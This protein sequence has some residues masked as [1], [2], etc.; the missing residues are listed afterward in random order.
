[1]LMSKAMIR[2]TILLFGAT[3][4]SG[5]PMASLAEDNVMVAFNPE[6][7]YT[8]GPYWEDIHLDE[9]AFYFYPDAIS[10][11]GTAV[12]G[13]GEDDDEG[14]TYT[15]Y[16]DTITGIVKLFPS[17]ELAEESANAISADGSVVVGRM[18]GYAAR[19]VVGETIT[20]D[21][22]FGEDYSSEAKH[23]SLD[24][25][26]VAGEIRDGLNGNRRVVHWD[27]ENGLT[28]VD[29]GA[30]W[31]LN[32]QKVAS[33]S[34][35][36]TTIIGT[37]NGD[38]LSD[39]AYR[40]TAETGMVDLRAGS[41]WAVGGNCCTTSRARAVSEDGRAVVGEAY[42]GNNVVRAFYWHADDGI[43]LD[44]ASTS[45]DNWASENAIRNG[46]PV[47]STATDISADG[48]TVI[49]YANAAERAFRWT[50][51]SG[52]V[53]LVRT[54]FDDGTT[55]DWG[56]LYTNAY[57]VSADGS[58]VVGEAYSETDGLN[59]A[60][61]WDESS[62]LVNLATGSD[63]AN[64]SSTAE[65]VSGD[66]S[67]IV[68]TVDS[69]YDPVSDVENE[70]VF[71]YK[72]ASSGGVMLDAANTQ[73]SIVGSAL[74]QGSFVSAVSAGLSNSVQTEL[75][76]DRNTR[77]DLVTRMAAMD[78]GS[79]TAK[80]PTAFRISAAQS[81]DDNAPTVKVGSVSAAVEL[82]DEL[83][84]GGFVGLGR[85]GTSPSGFGFSGY[86]T[87][88]GGFVRGKSFGLSGLT[89]KASFATNGGAVAIARDNSLTG[90]EA[91]T[92]TSDLR[93]YA[94]SFE[95]GYAIEAGEG[96]VSPYLRLTRTMTT[97][98]GYVEQADSFPVTFA[99]NNQYATI[100]TLGVNSKY[101]ISAQNTI[102]YGLG[103]DFD[104]TRNADNI[105]GSSEMPGMI[106]FSVAAPEV[107]NK[108]RIAFTTGLTHT[109]QNGSS[110]SFDL[111]VQ[112]N[113]YANSNTATGAIGYTMQF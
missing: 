100:A 84:V 61:R 19:W 35:D 47:N 62:G 20:V 21:K 67:V 49:G 82:S 80:M 48:S 66:G 3:A 18:D 64:T 12:I 9:Y 7:L 25:S 106:S 91:A 41:S 53:N 92:G 72:N 79:S 45:V 96:V 112:K 95:L 43:M 38:G 31:G 22:I 105:V 4:L 111:G 102:R 90:T 83:V 37:A 86:M 113:A 36:G 13:R 98:D 63:F 77:R 94:G 55:A 32:E 78:D 68:G 8:F 40:W 75:E 15:Y 27:T 30:M 104:L 28:H 6:P 99:E 51:A 87:T 50:E 54:D 76:I 58:V 93:S 33:I 56:A 65:F 71:I 81:S 89:W 17:V 26:A 23:V 110:I 10:D 103:V 85:D 73:T 74:A 107:V 88:F 101:E 29:E 16:L 14:Y 108:S 24:G 11:D 109:F 70:L 2:P 42:D 44:I 57:A 39:T 59:Q 5:L 46:W 97:L 52:L 34:R 1:M 69:V 60:F